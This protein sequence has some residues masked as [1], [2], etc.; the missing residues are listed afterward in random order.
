MAV[1]SYDWALPELVKLQQRQPDLVRSALE[2]TL[3]ED[4][5]LH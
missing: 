3:R 2:K 5:A 4:S 1:Q